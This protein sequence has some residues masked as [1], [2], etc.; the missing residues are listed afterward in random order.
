MS[1]EGGVGE[2]VGV[3]DRYRVARA[4]G[5]EM[6]KYRN[7]DRGGTCGWGKVATK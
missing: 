7:E 6:W 3:E 4:R 2:G 1:G 5:M